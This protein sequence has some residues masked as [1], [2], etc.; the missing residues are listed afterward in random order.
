[1]TENLLRDGI[2]AFVDPMNKLLEG[3]E[4]CARR[5]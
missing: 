5:S 3:I 4:R 1:V 2:Q